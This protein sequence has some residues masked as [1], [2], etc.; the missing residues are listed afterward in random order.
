MLQN[1]LVD[2]N[3]ILDVVLGR[4]GSAEVIR[5]FEVFDQKPN[6]GAWIAPH[7]PAI[8]HYVGR[9]QIGN[10]QVFVTLNQIAARFQIAPFTNQL[11]QDALCYGM[12]D[13]EDAMQSACADGIEAKGI[14]T[15][16]QK[17]FKNSP[18]PFLTPAEFV[19]Q[20]GSP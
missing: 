16:D 1:D 5:C 11:M 17:D 14:I 3:V 18:V 2:T 7:T 13:F 9:K 6:F 15:R 4:A 8:V 12:S 10:E 19:A 20:H